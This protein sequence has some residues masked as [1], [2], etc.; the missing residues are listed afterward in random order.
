MM[1]RQDLHWIEI[2]VALALMPDADITI[3]GIFTRRDTVSDWKNNNKQIFTLKIL[4]GKKL[5]KNL[6]LKLLQ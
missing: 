3:P 5:Q 2:L 6:V 4:C 1:L